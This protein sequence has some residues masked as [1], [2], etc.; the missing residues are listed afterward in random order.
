M[1]MYEFHTTLSI[2]LKTIVIPFLFFLTIETLAQE[3]PK[4]GFLD[5]AKV[6]Q[7]AKWRNAYRSHGVFPKPI[8]HLESAE[9]AV[10]QLRIV[11]RWVTL[12]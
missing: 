2:T 8:L 1:I 9:K 12:R 4:Q 10:L 5:S 3:H 7:I 11:V 6:I